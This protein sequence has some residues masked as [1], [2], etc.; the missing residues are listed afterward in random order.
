MDIDGAGGKG[1]LVGGGNCVQ[2]RAS[3]VFTLAKEFN[4][5]TT[6]QLHLQ[7]LNQLHLGGVSL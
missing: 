7:W 5:H 1:G 3:P 6:H 4:P 2:D